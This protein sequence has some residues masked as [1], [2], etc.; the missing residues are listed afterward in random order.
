MGLVG[1]VEAQKLQ[2]GPRSYPTVDDWS[3][4]LTSAI[5][6]LMLPRTVTT[7]CSRSYS[8]RDRDG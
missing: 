7:N 1:S 5:Q 6:S 8:T 2:N 3:S 4:N